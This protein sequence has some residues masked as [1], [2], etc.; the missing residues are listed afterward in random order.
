V[1]AEVLVVGAGPVGLALALDL[2]A[3]GRAPLVLEAR[4]GRPPGNRAIGIHPP[5]LAYLQRL[6]VA[7]ELI[8]RGVPVRRG[9]A[10][11]AQRPLGV[12]DFGRLGPPFPFVLTVPQPESEGTLRGALEARAP[13]S[14]R[15]G[16][17]LVAIEAGADS[18]RVTSR[19]LAG[20]ERTYRTAVVV[21][22]DG[23]ESTVRSLLGG[24]WRGAPYPDRFAMADLAD[25]DPRLAPD[26]ALVALT[27]AGVV[28]AFPLP[29]GV[30]RWVVRLAAGEG[31]AE[32]S[33]P[34]A[35]AGWVA[36]RVAQRSGF[37]P[38]AR[39]LGGASTF[40]VERRLADR[41]AFGRVLLAGDAAHVVSPIGGQ[42]MNLGWLDAAGY[43]AAIDLH[44]DGPGERL[45]RALATV[46]GE[47]RR[48]ARIALAR[49]HRNTLLGRPLSP[50][51]AGLR[52]ALL[53]GYLRP[54]LAGLARASFTMGGLA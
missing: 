45:Q 13:G 1:D 23:R 54:P 32:G 4:T 22:C 39:L 41:F 43:A 38:A 9:R 25:D 49:A 28:E 50:G 5:S 33:A 47:R 46:A 26:E 15:L 27:T 42:G 29:A 34:A 12:L 37:A 44:L 14:V 30:R 16:E 24:G 36:A 31:L 7:A 51:F 21:A 2:A 35:I 20:A 18:V 10:W 3:R 53:W 40:G 48:R 52:D 8:G 6:G 17:R 19:T 11:G